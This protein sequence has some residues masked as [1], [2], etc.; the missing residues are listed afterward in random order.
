M[1][2]EEF[3]DYIQDERFERAVALHVKAALAESYAEREEEIIKTIKEQRDFLIGNTRWVVMGFFGL[4]VIFGALTTFV[5][6]AQIDDKYLD[7]FIGETVSSSVEEKIEAHVAVISEPTLDQMGRDINAAATV[8]KDDAILEVRSAVRGEIETLLDNEVLAKIEEAKAEF[9][10]LSTSE[11][12]G[13]LVPPGAVIAFDLSGGCPVGWQEFYEVAG[14]TIIGVG[15]GSID[16]IGDQDIP[17]TERRWR[18]FGG[19]ETHILTSSEMPLHNH[20][21]IGALVGRDMTWY[22]PNESHPVPTNDAAPGSEFDWT[23]GG[24]RPH[25]IMQPYVAL[26]FCKKA[27]E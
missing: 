5:F 26:Y 14:R 9:L 10:T 20:D 3:N 7:H 19:A 1:A 2:T 16:Q 25:S 22:G 27:S 21:N 17:L 15:Q 4:L 24:G 18:D 6:G 13:D 23:D 8:V 12:V 11:V